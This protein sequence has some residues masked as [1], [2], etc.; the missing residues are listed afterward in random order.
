MMIKILKIFLRIQFLRRNIVKCIF[1]PS[2]SRKMINDIELS[3]SLKKN[4]KDIKTLYMNVTKGNKISREKLIL[5]FLFGHKLIV[6]A[7]NIDKEIIGLE[8][9]YFNKK[10]LIEGTI[11]QGFRGVKQEK[12]GIGIGTVITS[13]AIGH[14]KNAGLSGISSRVSL[15]NIS[16]LRSNQKLGF[17]PVE[18]YY[19]K[20]MDEQRYYLI[21]DFKDDFS[22]KNNFFS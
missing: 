8:L 21:C 18:E 9:Y 1:L 13:H 20:K 4:L 15:N 3:G 6:V 19:D 22:E 7:K 14:F 11:H 12:Q 5:Y 16:S 2:I 17:H 10:D